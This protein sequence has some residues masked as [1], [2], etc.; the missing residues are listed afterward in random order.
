MNPLGPCSSIVGSASG[1]GTPKLD[2]DGP[3]PRTSTVLGSLPVMMKPPIPTW[4]PVSTSIRVD[5]LSACAAPG[6]AVGVSVG[7]GVGVGV[8]TPTVAV[9]VGVNVAV[10]VALTVGVPVGVKVAVG[11]G[12][13]PQLPCTLNT[14]CMFGNPSVATGVGFVTPQAAA[15][16]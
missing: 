16:R 8:T 12:D 1:F 10:G 13:P 7:V 6:V 2:K 9:A 3:I 5:R 14:R 4:S 11:V 15:L